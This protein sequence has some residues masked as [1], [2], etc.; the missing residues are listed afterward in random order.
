[1]KEKFMRSMR[2]EKLRKDEADKYSWM[3]HKIM[4]A[5]YH[6]GDGITPETAHFSLGPA[7]GQNFIHK[8]IRADIGTMGS[9]SDKNGNFVDILE[10]K[11]TD[12]SGEQQTRN[13]Y[14]QIQHATNTMFGDMNL[15]S[16]PSKKAKSKKKKKSK[17]K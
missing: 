12:D 11:W 14:F 16:L 7:D 3:F 10:M 17:K 6:S 9:G 13:L 15:D 2:K 8:F 1:M 4:S 5:M